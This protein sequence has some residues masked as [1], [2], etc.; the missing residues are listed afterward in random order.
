MMYRVTTCGRAVALGLMVMVFSACVLARGKDKPLEFPYEAFRAN[1]KTAR[2]L[3]VYDWMAWQSSDL[4]MQEPEEEVKKLGREWF[5][6]QAPDGSW[7]AIYGRYEP[8]TKKYET[9][10]HY[11]RR[12]NA[13]F[14]RTGEVVDPEIA[15]RYGRA[16]HGALTQLPAEVSNLNVSFN[17]YIRRLE[18]DKLEVW[19]LPAGQRDGILVYG[20]DL[21]YV[22]DSSG[23]D[24]LHQEL[25][26]K[27]FR[28]VHSDPKVD[29]DIDRQGNDVPSVGDIFF[30][31]AFRDQFNSVT[32]WTRCFLTRI[33][34]VKGAEAEWL[35]AQRTRRDCIER[36]R[37]AQDAGRAKRMTSVLGRLSNQRLHR[38]ADAA[39]ESQS[40]WPSPSYG[41]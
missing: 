41:G 36:V 37:S 26:F 34:D 15:A 9:I 39:G 21:R 35:H 29:L 40:R 31:L 20:G 17:R 6:F 18:D 8:D 32:V 28:G 22:F 19:V 1:E 23:S 14:V 27:E 24:L 12:E 25:N 13:A 10:F 38:T 30:L 7:H 5:C 33:L 11:V 16:L 2:W 3:L 4:A